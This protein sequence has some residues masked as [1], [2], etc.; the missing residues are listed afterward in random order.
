MGDILPL[1]KT[2]QKATE[3]ELDPSEADKEAIR[4]A[5]QKWGFQEKEIE[6]VLVGLGLVKK[7]FVLGEA[8]LEDISRLVNRTLTQGATSISLRI[9]RGSEES[10][11]FHIEV[12]EVIGPE[13]LKNLRK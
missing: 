5:L 1:K 9:S 13:H 12:I 8:H 4:D 3:E 6:E 2:Y 10:E 7:G 11:H